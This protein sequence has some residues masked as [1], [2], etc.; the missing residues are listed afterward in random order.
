MESIALLAIGTRHCS[1][2]RV[3]CQ[4]GIKNVGREPSWYWLHPEYHKPQLREQV[5][6]VRM[7]VVSPLWRGPGNIHDV[8]LGEQS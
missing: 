1:L 3:C 6:N 2:V 4:W 8:V 5:S 7:V